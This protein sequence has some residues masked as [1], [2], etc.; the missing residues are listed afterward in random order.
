MFSAKH[1]KFKSSIYFDMFVRPCHLR[2]K[3]Q[4]IIGLSLIKSKH[5]VIT[6]K[7]K[8]IYVLV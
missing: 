1:Y 4:Q 5:K 3:K 7:W 6:I 2:K 8:S